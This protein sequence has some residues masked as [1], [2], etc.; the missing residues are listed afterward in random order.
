MDQSYDIMNS[1]EVFDLMVFISHDTE[2]KRD[3]RELRR[4][5]AHLLNGKEEL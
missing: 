1:V 3:A 2:S 4:R 5:I